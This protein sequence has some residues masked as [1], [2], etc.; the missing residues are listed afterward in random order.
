MQRNIREFGGDPKRVTIVG[1]SAGAQSVDLLLV[2]PPDPAPFA[3]AIMQSGQMTVYRL[4]SKSEESWKSLVS[5]TNCG[6]AHSPL[7][8]VR[9]LPADQVIKVVDAKELTFAPIVDGGVTFPEQGRQDRQSS[10]PGNS[11]IARV[12]VLLGTTA[13]DGSV[14]AYGTGDLKTALATYLPPNTSSTVVNSILGLYD[15]LGIAGLVA[16]LIGPGGIIDI[17]V[18]LS[19]LIAAIITDLLALCPASVLADDNEKAGIPTWRYYYDAEFPNNQAFPG[20]GAWHSSEIVEIFDT[21]S[22]NGATALQKQVSVKMQKAWADFAKYP[23]KGPGWA[24]QPR[25]GVY[26]DGARPGLSD[27][28]RQAFKTIDDSEIDYRCGLYKQLYALSPD[29]P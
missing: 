25:V 1:E 23:T 6:S 22:R 26:G 28:G 4:K 19:P 9:N 5:E 13:N 14:F 7:E 29:G 10:T 11:K 17:D 21:Y 15:K 27:K 3:G 8:C 2:A 12:P 24:M 20:S 18:D 16:S